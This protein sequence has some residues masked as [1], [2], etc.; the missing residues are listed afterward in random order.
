MPP[1]LPPSEGRYGPIDCEKVFCPDPEAGNIFA[2]SGIRWPAGCS[3]VMRPDR[4]VAHG[5]PRGARAE[6]AAFF[7][8]SRQ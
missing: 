5:L 1:L 7:D 8:R 4:H 2:L 3:A 6:L